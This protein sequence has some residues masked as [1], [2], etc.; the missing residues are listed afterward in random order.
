M[1]MAAPAF[2]FGISGNVGIEFDDFE[3]IAEHPMAAPAMATFE[4]LFEGLMEGAPDSFLNKKM[5][6]SACEEPAE[7][8]KQ[9]SLVNDMIEVFCDLEDPAFNNISIMTAYANFPLSSDVEIHSE[10]IGTGIKLAL[11]AGLLKM[12]AGKAG[13]IFEKEFDEIYHD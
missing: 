4:Q 9:M 10:S 7:V 6:L 8:K 5:D 1:M 11:K 13:H 2:I 3:E 12:I